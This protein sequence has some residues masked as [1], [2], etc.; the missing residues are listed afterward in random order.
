M[1]RDELPIHIGR[2]G[3]G[4]THDADAE[5]W[6]ARKTDFRRRALTPTKPGRVLWGFPTVWLMGQ[7]TGYW[8]TMVAP[9][10]E[11]RVCR[12]SWKMILSNPIDKTRDAGE[13]DSGRSKDSEWKD[14][15]QDGGRKKEASPSGIPLSA[16]GI[17]SAGILDQSR[18]KADPSYAGI[19]R[20]MPVAVR[21]TGNVRAGTTKSSKP[22]VCARPYA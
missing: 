8:K 21:P 15:K 4:A 7:E 6:C 13:V 1:W 16:T 22:W 9:K 3:W 19:I 2:K 17:K 14:W 10:L 11:E 5:R 18:W 20:R 12:A